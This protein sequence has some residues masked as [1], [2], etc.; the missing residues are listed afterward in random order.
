MAQARRDTALSISAVQASSSAKP[1]SKVDSNGAGASATSEGPKPPGFAGPQG[2]K[3]HRMPNLRKNI[4]AKLDGARVMASLVK[5]AASGVSITRIFLFAII[6]GCVILL[7]L[8][9]NVDKVCHRHV[10]YDILYACTWL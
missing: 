6:G 4:A 10:T 2:G 9:L 7:M 8:M 5:A 3:H 1:A